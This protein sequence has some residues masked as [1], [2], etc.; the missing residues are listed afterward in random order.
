MSDWRDSPSQFG[1][2]AVRGIGVG[3]LVLIVGL[4]AIVARAW[5]WG[6]W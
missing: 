3:G 5:L 2:D 6:A 4:V 1:A